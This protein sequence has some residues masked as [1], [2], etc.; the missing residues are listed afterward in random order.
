MAKILIV[1]ITIVFTLQVMSA[2]ARAQSL[3]E[4]VAITISLAADETAQDGDIIST[5]NEGFV[6]A[7]TAYD[8][9]L[10]GVIADSPAVALE[11]SAIE[12]GKLVITNGKGYVRVR[13]QGEPIRKGDFITSSDIPGVGQKANQSGYVLG[14]ALEDFA[15]DNPEDIGKVLVSLDIRFNSAQ[16]GRANL[17]QIVRQGLEAPFLTPLGALRYLLAS[18]ITVGSFVLAFLSFGRVARGGVEALGRNPLASR[19]IEVTVII[20][21]VLT[22]AILLVGLGISY[23]ILIL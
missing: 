8:P 3:T 6:L 13:T 19:V 1:A 2:L 9:M 14:I 5:S 12:A 4:A 21:V 20:N 11:N 7:K 16:N 17:I 10:Y 18:L 15:S 23:L 22:V